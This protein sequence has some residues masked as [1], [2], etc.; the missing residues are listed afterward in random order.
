[1]D[2]YSDMGR[3]L[4]NVGL[5]IIIVIALCIMITILSPLVRVSANYIV[6][7]NTIGNY[8][9]YKAAAKATPLWIYAFPVIIGGGLIWLELRAPIK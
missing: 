4:K 8:W 5:I 2:G 7:S 1:M 9:G 3:K 6:V